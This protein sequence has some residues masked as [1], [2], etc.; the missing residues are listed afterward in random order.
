MPSPSSPPPESSPDPTP[1]ATDPPA[2]S[3]AA[4][5]PRRSRVVP[6][7][8]H[9]H[10]LF[11]GAALAGS[12][13]AGIAP[14]LWPGLAATDRVLLGADLFFASY[15]AAALR[16]AG[17]DDRTALRRHVEDTDE[18][19]AL[20]VL[21]ALGAV[22]VS[23]WAIVQTVQSAGG[24][25]LRPW[26]ALA[27]VPLGWA[28]IQ[29][30]MTFHYAALYYDRAWLADGR[31]GPVQRG[32]SFAG[33]DGTPQGLWDFVYF[34]F[35]IGMTAQTSDTGVTTARMRRAT[36]GHAALSFFYNAVIVALAVSAGAALGR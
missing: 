26:L 23:L 36:T 17:R 6:R 34:S 27:A 9:R 28:T 18:G 20:I 14:L 8:R 1:P 24:I 15:L 13:A 30:I 7:P 2:R 12:A 5:Q 29:T 19:I 16:V 25:A 11:L 4:P 35:T 21:I 32:L 22:G 31:R 10:L 3:A 33:G